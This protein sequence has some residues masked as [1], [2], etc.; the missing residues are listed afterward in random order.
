MPGVATNPIDI[1]PT[2]ISLSIS[3]N[4]GASE[5]DVTL[6]N[7]LGGVGG[8]TKVSAFDEEKTLVPAEFSTDKME[9][10]PG[11]FAR[12]PRSSLWFRYG[13]GRG[14]FPSDMHWSG[15]MQNC[16]QTGIFR[17]HFQGWGCLRDV[18]NVFHLSNA[19]SCNDGMG[20]FFLGESNPQKTSSSWNA[21]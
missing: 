4:S 10:Q 16:F 11:Q 7:P 18:S 17:C 1:G 20:T 13:S 21:R 19:S 2:G 9:G 12:V 15:G 6:V 14:I 5:Q 8:L 3:T